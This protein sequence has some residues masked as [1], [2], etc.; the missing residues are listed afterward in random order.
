VK[1][2]VDETVMNDAEVVEE[3]WRFD[4]DILEFVL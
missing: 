2:E 3:E 4:G 1:R